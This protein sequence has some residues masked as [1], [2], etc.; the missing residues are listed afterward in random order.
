MNTQD[1]TSQTQSLYG[2]AWQQIAPGVLIALMFTIA[3]AAMIHAHSPVNASAESFHGNPASSPGLADLITD[4]R[5]SIAHSVRIELPMEQLRDADGRLATSGESLFMLLARRI[6]SLSLD[7]MLTADSIPNAEFAAVIAA[8]MMTEANLDAAQL[9]IGIHERSTDLNSANDSLLVVIITM[10]E[11]I[12][13][14]VK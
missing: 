14:V 10:H 6:K 5:N 2:A 11:T 13:G 4:P 9:R 3:S 7:V 8:R 1:T 12:A